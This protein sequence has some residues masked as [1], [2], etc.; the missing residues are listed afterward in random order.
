MGTRRTRSDSVLGGGRRRL[1]PVVC[2][3]AAVLCLAATGGRAGT[4]GTVG[5]SRY[6]VA[7]NKEVREIDKLLVAR[8][9][10]HAN[11]RA[12][13]LLK[14]ISGQVMTGGREVIGAAVLERAVALAGLGHVRDAEWYACMASDFWDHA[15]DQLLRYGTL[16]RRLRRAVRGEGTTEEDTQP[17]LVD[18]DEGAVV[19]YPDDLRPAHS[20]HVFHEGGPTR[21]GLITAPAVISR[22]QLRYPEAV[23]RTKAEGMVVVML[24]INREGKPKHPTVVQWSPYVPVVYLALDGLKDWRF[25]PATLNGHPVE[26]LYE[27]TVTFTP[28]HSSPG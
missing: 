22:R 27:L 6:L 13:K 17:V 26:V 7:W 1:V 24:T 11:H 12:E 10:K 5:R 19:L 4:E 9:W 21:H 3:I 23:F 15:A 20:E 14:R 8:D 28:W 16:G 25:K 18:D 2:L